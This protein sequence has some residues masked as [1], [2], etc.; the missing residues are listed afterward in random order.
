MAV[1]VAAKNEVIQ[2]KPLLERMA[3]RSQSDDRPPRQAILL[4]QLQLI[5]RRFQALGEEEHHIASC[6]RIEAGQL[7][8]ASS[9]F[10]L[11]A[12][13]ADVADAYSPRAV[14]Q[15]LRLDS[16]IDP[17]VPRVMTSERARLYQVLT[18][19]LDNAVKF[20]HAGQVSLTVRTTTV[21]TG[22]AVE[23]IV[24]D[25]GIG[26][27]EEHQKMVFESFHQVDGSMTRSYGGNGLGLAICQELTELMGGSISLQSQFGA[28]STFVARIPL[29]GVPAAQV[30]PTL[31]TV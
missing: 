31:R 29:V 7:K 24:S 20:T 28:G 18:N 2:F 13:V 8:L 26:I 6:Q 10:D 12:M 15:G 30:T 11:H 5:S 16:K 22:S 17:D 4:D 9:A 25:T 21:D 14:R 19:L 3:G 23:F 1:V 27:P